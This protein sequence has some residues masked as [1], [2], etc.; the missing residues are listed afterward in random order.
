LLQLLPQE[1]F[2]LFHNQLWSEVILILFLAFLNKAIWQLVTWT[3]ED[4]FKLF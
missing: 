3:L 4:Y 1:K 2:E